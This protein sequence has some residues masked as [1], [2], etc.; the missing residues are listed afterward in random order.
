M[1]ICD[2]TFCDREVQVAIWCNTHWNQQHI[3]HEFTPI[4][5]YVAM[6]PAMSQAIVD[7]I[8]AGAT[9]TS[10]SERFGMNKSTVSREFKKITG[11]SV[12]D[13]K[14]NV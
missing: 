6:T 13:F 14:V 12:H 4:Q 8:K 7:A 9:I 3:G 2:V 1:R 5:E 10:L 11:T